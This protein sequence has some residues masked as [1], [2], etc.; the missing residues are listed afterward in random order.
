MASNDIAWLAGLITTM[1]SAA[2]W[3]IVLVTRDYSAIERRARRAAIIAS[4][5]A[6]AAIWGVTVTVY[7]ISELMGNFLIFPSIGLTAIAVWHASRI[8]YQKMGGGRSPDNS[9]QES[10]A[11]G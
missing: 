5:T 11:R 6:S 7:S 9:T 10:G 2:I 3:F 8:T 1:I 4:V